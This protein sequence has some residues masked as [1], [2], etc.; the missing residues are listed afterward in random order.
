MVAS[1]REGKS[2]RA[3]AVLA[4]VFAAGCAG[5]TTEP[6]PAVPDVEWRTSSG[7]N[8]NLKYSPLDQINR[9]NVGSLQIA[10]RQSA[11]P[12][13][14]RHGL[15]QVNISTNHQTAPLMIDGVLYAMTP[16]LQAMAL[17]PATGE[18]LWVDIPPRQAALPALPEGTQA[19]I[20]DRRAISRGV[21]YWADGDDKRILFI[22]GNDMI[23]VNA[24][25][26]DRISTFGTDGVVDMRQSYEPPSDS[27][28]WGGPPVIVRDVAV[29]AGTATRA[30]RP[31]PADIRG[32]DVRTGER[33]WTFHSIPRPGE[34]GSD[35]YLGDSLEKN[36]IGGGGTWS[37]LSGD[38]ELGYVYIPGD[39]S[40]SP[41]DFYGALR[42]GANLFEHSVICV[43]AAT[44]ERVWHFQTIRHGLW[45]Y[46][47]PTAP[48]LID[49]TVDGRQIKALAQPSK[50]A[51]LYV[52]DRTTGEPVWPVEDRPVPA[53]DV[54]GEW[55]SP[56][57]P[58]PT[59]PPPYDRQHLLEE[60]LV[61]FTPEIRA[62]AKKIVDQYV[63]GDVFTPPTMYDPRPGGK[64]GTLMIGT[65]QTTWPGAG[66][67]PDTNILYVTSVHSPRVMGMIKAPDDD[68][69]SAYVLRKTTEE[70]GP[71]DF[72][73]GPLNLPDPFKPPYGRFVAI[74]LNKGEILWSVANGDCCSQD[75]ALKDLKL[76]KLGQGG[77]VAPLVTKTMV[78]LG[79]GG[80]E[81]PGA[82]H[83]SGGKMFRA[84]DKATGDIIAEI[85]LP[86]GTT[87]PPVTYMLNGKQY[88]VVAVAAKDLPAEFIAL[89]LP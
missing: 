76:P 29:V 80:E 2:R 3:A 42:P 18:V 40:V 61:D 33:K 86:G 39:T 79:E 22:S 26:G 64:K 12:V 25:T 77:R 44:G 37:L 36:G 16:E 11:T 9:E 53:G 8:A 84:Y 45:D 1:M 73:Q 82:P 59:R 32:F 70:V 43:N 74:D 62:E 54:P 6:E 75:P 28:F 4:A 34:F 20:V 49:I 89:T 60:D 24:E 88:I 46:D 83:R 57:Q 15:T 50:V 5:T 35:T 23:A 17:D 71:G 85:E 69:P 81:I 31:I 7:T 38:D 72:V 68:A 48:S 78:F 52:L 63:M 55:Y 47:L 66:V 30:G 56:T 10:W 41:N 87:G 19:E 67:D 21:A 51:Y 14:A 65:S 13:E 58:H 27:F